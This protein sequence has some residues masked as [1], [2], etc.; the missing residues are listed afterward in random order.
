MSNRIPIIQSPLWFSDLIDTSLLP[1]EPLVQNT[2]LG[3]YKRR[4]E[5][6]KAADHGEIPPWTDGGLSP[7]EYN[8]MQQ[9]HAGGGLDSVNRSDHLFYLA[10]QL[11]L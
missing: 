7:S 8:G 9:P 1:G 2:S 5:E 10:G 4:C 6:N 3:K 11:G